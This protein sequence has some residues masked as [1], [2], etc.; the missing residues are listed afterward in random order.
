[1]SRNH[2]KKLTAE[3]LGLLANSEIANPKTKRELP[4]KAPPPRFLSVNHTAKT[5]SITGS[6]TRTTPTLASNPIS[7]LTLSPATVPITYN[8]NSLPCV[9]NRGA[10]AF[11]VPVLG[12]PDLGALILD[13]RAT[14]LLPD[15]QEAKREL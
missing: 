1:M 13:S 14:Q 11:A 6:N 12:A 5:P 2:P 7:I 9:P 10:S 8:L 15:S 3:L 4:I